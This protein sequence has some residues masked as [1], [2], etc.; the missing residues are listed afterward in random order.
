PHHGV[1]R[2]QPDA[3]RI[4]SG[5]A[6]GWGVVDPTVVADGMDQHLAV[7]W[8]TGEQPGI[9]WPAVIVDGDRAPPAVIAQLDRYVL[10]LPRR[11]GHRRRRTHLRRAGHIGGKYPSARPG[12]TLLRTG[13]KRQPNHHKPQPE[14]CLL[15]RLRFSRRQ[16]APLME[17]NCGRRKASRWWR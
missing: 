14:P 5:K 7:L 15:H 9:E 12:W 8:R 16:R 6:W 1:A 11:R 13:L 4:A 3:E 17:R 2:Q 10:S